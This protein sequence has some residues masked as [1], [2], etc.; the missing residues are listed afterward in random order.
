MMTIFKLAIKNLLGAGMRTWLNVIVLSFCFVLI[1]F[2]QG[3]LE[4]TNR[5]VA[6]DMINSVYGGG[7]IWHGEYDSYDPLSLQDAHGALPAAVKELADS[8]RAVPQLIM[9]GSI[10]PEGRFISVLLRGIDPAQ[11][12]LDLPMEGLA[13]EMVEI[14]VIIGS[15][16]A[17]DSG[18]EEGDTFMVRWRDADGTF[19]AQEAKVVRV[20]K[21]TAQVADSG[22]L[23]IPLERLRT[24]GRMEGEATLVVLDQ[25]VQA[26]VAEDGWI[27]RDQNYLLSDLINMIKS[28]KAGSSIYYLILMF[29][30]M[31][32]IFNTQ[33]LSVFRRR[34]EMGTLMALG[35]TRGK[36]IR[37]FTLEGALHAILAVLVGALYGGPLLYLT[38]AKGIS[39]PASYDQWGFAIGEKLYSIYPAGL[40]IGTT[41]LVFI[42]TTIVSFLPTR[43][44]SKLKPTD[45]LRGRFSS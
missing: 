11:T 45:A 34:K 32:A 7:Q 14:P 42:I 10:Y 9:Q 13:V 39:L 28:K 40:I 26:P 3:M 33:M 4:G 8:G 16:M 15:R 29:M 25:N 35:F 18:L 21:T 27:Y 6:N 41:L 12:I 24:M 5:Q 22:Q 44:I 19:D 30:A 23:W 38:A 31:L 1:I 2:F 20:F 36:V 43:K 17:R 37:L